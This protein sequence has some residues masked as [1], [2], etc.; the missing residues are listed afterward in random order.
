MKYMNLSATKNIQSIHKT[1]M[2]IQVYML[3]DY[4]FKEDTYLYFTKEI[5]TRAYLH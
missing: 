3:L 5:I 2:Y 1:C 4:I